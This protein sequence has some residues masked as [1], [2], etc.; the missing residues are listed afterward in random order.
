M[1]YLGICHCEAIGFTYETA[2]APTAWPLRA[3]ACRFCRSHGAVTTSDPHGALELTGR[4]R[5]RLMRYRF[6]LRTADFCVC[7]TCGVYIAAVTR[8]GRFGIIN[9]NALVDRPVP[10]SPPQP[11]SYDGETTAARTARREQRWT[12]MRPPTV[13]RP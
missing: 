11:M 12:P 9:T 8:D 13:E 6:E 1:L 5:D 3:C 10:L 4:D 7:S 2:V